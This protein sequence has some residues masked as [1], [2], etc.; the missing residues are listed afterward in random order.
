M[1]AEEE[2]EWAVSPVPSGSG[3][4]TVAVRAAIAGLKHYIKSATWSIVVNVAL[5]AGQVIECQLL[6]GAAVI[7]RCYISVPNGA[8][9]GQA[10]TCSI[11]GLNLPCTPGNTA[12][13]G[14]SAAA[15]NCQEAASLAGTTEQQ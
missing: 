4:A 1:I 15:A 14:F 6:D 2:T 7:W 11:A 13:A 12:S 8:P 10:F 5:A 9:V 3:V